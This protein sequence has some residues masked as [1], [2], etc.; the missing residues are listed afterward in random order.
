MLSVQY[1]QAARYYSYNSC[2]TQRSWGMWGGGGRYS[3]KCEFW[4][5][6]DLNNNVDARKH[7]A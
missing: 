2:T 6:T 4:N 3:W 1:N 7:M 5:V